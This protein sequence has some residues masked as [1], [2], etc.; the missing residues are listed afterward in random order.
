MS[1]EVERFRR[2]VVDTQGVLVYKSFSTR[3]PRSVSRAD[4]EVVLAELDAM[5]ELLAELV[6]D[7]PCWL[8][9]HGYCQGHSRFDP[10]SEC[11]HARAKRLLGEEVNVRD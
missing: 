2:F 11:P 7:E 8:D 4:T 6:S 10:D 5:R 1:G 9:H 3:G